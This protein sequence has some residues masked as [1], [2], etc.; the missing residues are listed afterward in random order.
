VPHHVPCSDDSPE[1]VRDKLVPAFLRGISSHHAGCLPAWKSLVE[2]CFQ[3]GLLKLVFA[4]GEGAGVRGGG[5]QLPTKSVLGVSASA[6]GAV[7]HHTCFHVVLIV[8][9]Y[10]PAPCVHRSWPKPVNAGRV[11]AWGP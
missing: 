9:L 4:T 3:K 10:T 6:E 5:A 7:A 2:R 11:G 8:H 1:G